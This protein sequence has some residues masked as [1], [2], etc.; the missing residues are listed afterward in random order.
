MRTLIN[1]RIVYQTAHREQQLII[2]YVIAYT[3][4]KKEKYNK[5]FLMYKEILRT[6]VPLPQT[7][8]ESRRS[9]NDIGA[10]SGTV[11]KI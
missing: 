10:V 8:C 9:E 2:Y 11:F 1:L 5:K 6:E 3:E 4:N 7:D